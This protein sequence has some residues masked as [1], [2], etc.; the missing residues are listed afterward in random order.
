MEEKT[1]GG[2]AG[3]KI[4]G[5]PVYSCQEGAYLGT[6][7][8]ALIDQNDYVV[9]GFVLEKRRM[10]KEERILPFAEVHCFGQDGVTVNTA[11]KLE[12]IGQ[13][14]KYIR[15]LRHPLAI[16]GA[17][18]FTTAGRTLGK[19]EDYRFDPKS[20]VLC[21]FE[22]S[23]DGFFKERTLVNGA[24]LIA[25]S[26]NTVMLREEAT[27][28]AVPLSSLRST[29]NLVKEKAGEFVSNTAGLTKRCAAN[30]NAQME[31]LK[32]REPSSPDTAEKAEER[33]EAQEETG[34][35]PAPNDTDDTADTVADTAAAG[36]E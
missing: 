21:G 11:E 30:I 2:L 9:K 16:I 15:P 28:D 22:V 7:R 14:S 6:V 19:V 18:V 34:K 8:S 27:E 29:A 36:E 31:K 25:I 4:L 3:K 33:Q 23:P 12:R 35:A 20:G 24:H 26:E 13:N 17:R 10:P 32:K 5:L 1:T